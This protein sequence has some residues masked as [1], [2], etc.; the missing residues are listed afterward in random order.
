LAGGIADQLP[1]SKTA[2][3][4]VTAVLT[5][6]VAQ[7]A[8]RAIAFPSMGESTSNVSEVWASTRC[9]FIKA[10]ASGFISAAKALQ[11]GALAVFADEVVAALAIK[12]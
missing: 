8:A 4:H 2:R 12:N 5:S 6:A 1:F 9:P 3:A 7:R 11:L 10:R